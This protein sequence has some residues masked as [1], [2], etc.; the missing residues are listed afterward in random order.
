MSPRPTLLRRCHR[1]AFTLIE[2]L[3]VIAIIAIL[4]V[5]I[6]TLSS[7]ML[8]GEA[9]LSARLSAQSA[10]T[11]TWGALARDLAVA[12][13]IAVSDGP[14][15]STSTLTLVSARVD[16]AGE[17]RVAYRVAGG[18]LLR[19]VDDGPETLLMEPIASFLA[20]ADNGICTI[21]MRGERSRT[22]RTVRIRDTASFDLPPGCRIAP[23]PPTGGATQ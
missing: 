4:S 23:I 18:A 11:S 13:T 2:S 7:R 8:H 22:G 3:I 10:L 12:R 9:E 14:T 17:R 1:R 20:H 6:G 19:R 16:P 21:E 15:T 5:V